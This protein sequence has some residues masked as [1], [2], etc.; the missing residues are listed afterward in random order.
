MNHSLHYSTIFSFFSSQYASWLFWGLRFTVFKVLT[1]NPSI[2]RKLKIRHNNTYIFSTLYFRWKNHPFTLVSSFFNLTLPN[3]ILITWPTTGFY[4]FYFFSYDL[5]LCHD[6]HSSVD[7]SH[8]VWHRRRACI[9]LGIYKK[10]D[11]F[12]I[13]FSIGFSFFVSRRIFGK[14]M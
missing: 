3:F 10:V 4:W 12:C 2:S 11:R 5:Y 6:R 14:R 13:H 8:G 7:Y 1:F 9:Y